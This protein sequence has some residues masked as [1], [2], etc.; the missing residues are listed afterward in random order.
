MKV[1]DLFKGA[2]R[3]AK[4]SDDVALAIGNVIASLDDGLKANLDTAL[5]SGDVDS[6][7]DIRKKITE[8]A[9]STDDAKYFRSDVFKAALNRISSD[10][11]F[12]DK[13]NEL[14][15]QG[16]AIDLDEMIKDFSQGYDADNIAHVR[17]MR[18]VLG[19]RDSYI[20]HRAGKLAEWSNT[21]NYDDYAE[22]IDE[23]KA[24]WKER[25]DAGKMHYDLNASPRD[26]E[27]TNKFNAVDGGVP[28][29]GANNA[30]AAR[31]L[32]EYDDFPEFS[33]WKF[34]K[35]KL[36]AHTGMFDTVPLPRVSF[37]PVAAMRARSYGITRPVL[38]YV[39]SK[40]NNA[41]ITDGL[42]KLNKDVLTSYKN[43]GDAKAII[44][45]FATDNKAALEEFSDN[46]SALK[47]HVEDTYKTNAEINGK[48]DKET[49]AFIQGKDKTRWTSDLTIAQKDAL[50]EYLDHMQELAIDITQ[51]TKGKNSDEILANLDK[52]KNGELKLREV[53][54]SVT[55]LSRSAEIAASEHIKKTGMWLDGSDEATRQYT[56]KLIRG[57][58]SG[59]YSR[60]S[61][62]GDPIIWD[63]NHAENIELQ[64]QDFVES[65]TELA[66]DGT[67]KI[68]LGGDVKPMDNFL[69]YID[70]IIGA[71]FA[72][73]AIF[74]TEQLTGILQKGLKSG[75]LTPFPDD[76]EFIQKLKAT[77]RYQSAD[78]RTMDAYKKIEKVFKIGT[79]RMGPAQNKSTFGI[80]DRFWEVNRYTITKAER[81]SYFLETA[82]RHGRDSD[83]FGTGLGKPAWLSM[84]S[85]L[86]HD[87]FYNPLAFITGGHTKV[88]SSQALTGDNK[89]FFKGV[90]FEWQKVDADGKKE[91]MFN[92]MG[93]A[94]LNASLGY[95][96]DGPTETKWLFGKK[97]IPK[98]SKLGYAAL[99]GAGLQVGGNITDNDL[100]T[101]SGEWITDTAT[102]PVQWMY[103]GI[104]GKGNSTTTIDAD[105]E[106][107]E[108]EMSDI[109]EDITTPSD[110]TD[111]IGDTTFGF[112][113]S[114]NIGKVRDASKEIVEKAELAIREA[115]KTIRS[116][117]DNRAS[118]E[119]S[120]SYANSKS[121]TVKAKKIEKLISDIPL[122]RND[123][124]EIL[125]TM[126][127]THKAI[128]K[129]DLD[130][131]GKTFNDPTLLENA[132]KEQYRDQVS[133]LST[134]GGLQ[135]EIAQIKQD[136]L[137][138]VPR[139][140][141][142]I[143]EKKK[144]A[145]ASGVI[146]EGDTNGD[147]SSSD[148]TS[149]DVK[150]EKPET[151]A[152][153]QA[154]AR[155]LLKKIQSKNPITKVQKVLNEMDNDLKTT[156]NILDEVARTDDS[157]E[158]HTARRQL[159]SFM[160][161]KRGLA[162]NK[163]AAIQSN[164]GI[165]K[166]NNLI[167]NAKDI[168]NQVSNASD[169]TEAKALN[170]KLSD[171]LK[172]I[173]YKY[174]TGIKDAIESAQGIAELM[175]DNAAAMQANDDIKTATDPLNIGIRQLGGGKG[176]ALEDFT[177]PGGILDGTGNILKG[178]FNKFSDIWKDLENG[179][180]TKESDTWLKWGKIAGITGLGG[181]ALSLYNGVT[182]ASMNITGGWG[183]AVIL[184][185]F[186]YA[187]RG[188]SEHNTKLEANN[189]D[190]TSP[191]R[192]Y[193]SS[194]RTGVA[195]Y[196]DNLNSVSSGNKNPGYSSPVRT[197]GRLP[198]AIYNANGDD[199]TFKN[200]NTGE[201]N[202]IETS[203]KY[204]INDEHYLNPQCSVGVGTGSGCNIPNGAVMHGIGNSD[205]TIL[206]DPAMIEASK[207]GNGN[208][209]PVYGE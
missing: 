145:D 102:T 22:H 74:A 89:N 96:T 17:D 168:Q 33:K 2:A 34:D 57:I 155:N 14:F 70:T 148:D 114:T 100:A 9:K 190:S 166:I 18:H 49:G 90:K 192:Q 117:G 63:V 174:K 97:S 180:R 194:L 151:I 104:L 185:V 204:G 76:S 149:T 99:L 81:E 115:Q 56:E 35:D 186:L 91:S 26:P 146:V 42:M 28:A 191:V 98:L 12:N 120:L 207:H 61:H 47:K 31:P 209:A 131:R 110:L 157:V 88:S 4:A 181:L 6:L 8:A 53:E 51:G 106:E 62:S 46:L 150:V 83:Y 162:A 142:V 171:T 202:K 86:Q 73:E 129:G 59:Y 201:T 15:A 24:H 38:D 27:A 13:F 193:S 136:V 11:R 139:P 128:E 75:K 152:G 118:L 135:T 25:Q 161:G 197:Q 32:K 188:S 10:I 7:D 198:N 58:N 183:E 68:K 205:D 137:N 36:I 55:G 79:D 87:L 119:Q 69:A 72:E 177:L 109:H 60:N 154:I 41:G 164:S 126:K 44:N 121:D 147:S 40:M 30:S 112:D 105:G 178:T 103:S 165:K 71:G 113:T 203:R 45:S 43:G 23:A 169:V 130:L 143:V 50:I 64:W 20:L 167:D 124:N 101:D 65:H 144:D 37:F 200:I 156:R 116:I 21:N 125:K 170:T 92:P 138:N 187:I 179:S 153:Q 77:S 172:S 173:K 199:V 108:I 208:W 195:G 80:A 175:K 52:I 141:K 16:A 5:K 158:K 133:A 54:E 94:S 29:S 184:G 206:A 82:R 196:H 66:D 127:E 132:I 93:R 84:K 19:Q 160:E 122:R 67:L 1:E 107:V 159:L 48:I 39:S 3:G 85:R 163:F 176:N 78:P 134:I 189:I 123:A 111:G 140:V 182:P 95:L